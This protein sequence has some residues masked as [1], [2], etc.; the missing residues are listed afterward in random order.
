[1]GAEEWDPAELLLYALEYLDMY[2]S[3]AFESEDPQESDQATAVSYLQTT[4][5]CIEDARAALTI[6]FAKPS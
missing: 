5:E 3:F 4:L 6:R 1:M 2:I